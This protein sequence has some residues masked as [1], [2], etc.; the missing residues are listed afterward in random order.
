MKVVKR[1]EVFGEVEILYGS[2]AR[3]RL[4]SDEDSVPHSLTSLFSKG[5]KMSSI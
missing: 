4:L 1:Q 2:L 5:L 3:K